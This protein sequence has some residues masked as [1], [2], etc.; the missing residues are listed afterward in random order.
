MQV[1][2][3]LLTKKEK[4]QLAVRILVLISAP[5]TVY[6]N[7]DALQRREKLKNMIMELANQHSVIPEI[8]LKQS[9]LDLLAWYV[10]TM[11]SY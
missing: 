2:S 8:L 11:F 5:P 4:V 6:W 3:P 1:S 10:S 9:T 7:E